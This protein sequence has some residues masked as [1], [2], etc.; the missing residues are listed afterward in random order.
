MNEQQDRDTVSNLREN[1]MALGQAIQEDLTKGGEESYQYAAY[2]ARI[3]GW[4]YKNSLNSLGE[5]L[6]SE[7]IA[8][9]VAK[10]WLRRDLAMMQEFLKG[11]RANCYT[12]LF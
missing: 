5:P 2:L 1:A 9:K 10:R 4:Q 11:F 6:Y 8:F 3:M 7:E 12:D